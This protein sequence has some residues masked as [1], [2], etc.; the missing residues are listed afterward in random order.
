MRRAVCTATAAAFASSTG[1]ASAESLQGAPK[2]IAATDHRTF[3]IVYFIRTINICDVFIL[4]FKHYIITI[5][6]IIRNRISIAI[7]KS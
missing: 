4:H 7:T 6:F 1:L 3:Y 5:T 2:M